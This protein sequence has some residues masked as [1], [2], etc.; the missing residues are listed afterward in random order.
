M[1]QWFPLGCISSPPRTSFCQSPLPSHLMPSFHTFQAHVC[2][3]ST[4]VLPFG[5]EAF[6][7]TSLPF[8]N[9]RRL[10]P[11]QDCGPL[12]FVSRTRAETRPRRAN[13]WYVQCE[14]CGLPQSPRLLCPLL[15]SGVS[16]GSA[17]NAPSL[18]P[19]DAQALIQPARSV[20]TCCGAVACRV[21]EPRLRDA[22][23]HSL[24]RVRKKDTGRTFSLFPTSTVI[25]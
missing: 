18:P 10:P 23:L 11:S 7:S 1:P 22:I 19:V 9:D 5:V 16:C 24:H 21:P 3:L 20:F 25:I 13:S 17:Q 4:S 14:P 6:L 8:G 12:T 15:F 2:Q